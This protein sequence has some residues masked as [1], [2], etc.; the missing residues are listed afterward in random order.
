MELLRRGPEETSDPAGRSDF[1]RQRD[2]GETP[3]RIPLIPIDV[4]AVATWRPRIRFS[5]VYKANLATR[6][7]DRRRKPDGQTDS[8]VVGLGQDMSRHFPN[9]QV[10]LERAS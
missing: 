7:A 1:C 6:I 10:R 9:Q 5:R 3:P 4:A 8:T 2:P